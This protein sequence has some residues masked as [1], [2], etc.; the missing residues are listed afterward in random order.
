[1]AVL[2]TLIV[3][4]LVV[5]FGSRNKKK[6][7]G[8]ADVHDIIN[9]YYNIPASGIL[10]VDYWELEALTKQMFGTKFRLCGVISDVDKT[11][12]SFDSA[13]ITVDGKNIQVFFEKNQNPKKGEYVEIVG[14][15]NTISGDG[16]YLADCTITERGN[17]VR[18]RIKK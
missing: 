12:S 16:I 15:I 11:F 18:E 1:M 2:L 8:T 5:H 13:K 14:T 17:S 7:N 3:V 4:L 6:S 9:A 10:D